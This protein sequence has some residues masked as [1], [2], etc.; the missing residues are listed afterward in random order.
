MGKASAA[1][2]VSRAARTGGGRTK[3]GSSSFLFPAAMALV[4]ILGVLLIISSRGALTVD[5][6]PPRARSNDSPGDHWHSAIGFDICGT[7]APPIQSNEDPLGIHTHGDGVIHIH[8]FFS[9]AAGKNATLGI[10]LDTVGAKVTEDEIRIP[11]QPTKKNGELCDGRPATVR[12]KVWPSRAADAVPEIYVGDPND[13]RLG[14][15]QLI[16]VAFVPD[17]VDIPK[18]PSEGALDNLSDVIPSSLP[19]DPSPV[20]PSPTD[21]PAVDPSAV[22]PSATDP[23]A[24]T[25]AGTDTTVGGGTTETTTAGTPTTAATTPTTTP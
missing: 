24:T 5:D 1:K 10:Y 3:R 4:V 23:T 25:V 22:D 13:L 17:D 18:P 6:T 20:D 14:D 2:K 9:R 12:V 7:F 19:V 15:S 8:P 21:P 11:G 16:T